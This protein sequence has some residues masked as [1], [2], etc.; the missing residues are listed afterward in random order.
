[1]TEPTVRKMVELNT[2]DVSW[3]NESYAGAHLSWVLTM[4]LSEFRK[5][6]AL[7]PIDYA[8]IAAKSL[9]GQIADDS[10]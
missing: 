8:A 6:H 7:A 3:F 5:C 4:L 2:E 9:E 1:M 10:T